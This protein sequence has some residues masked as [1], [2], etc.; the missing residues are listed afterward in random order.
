MINNSVFSDI[1]NKL[2]NLGFGKFIDLTL[3][4]F[5]EYCLVFCFFYNKMYEVRYYEEN[6]RHLIENYLNI[7]F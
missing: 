6:K 4:E 1:R 2:Y 7:V 3:K 5:G